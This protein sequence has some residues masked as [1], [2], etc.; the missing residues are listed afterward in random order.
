MTAPY[1]CERVVQFIGDSN[2]TNFNRNRLDVY[3][4]NYPCGASS[5]SLEH[6]AQSIRSGRFAY[7][8]YGEAKNLEVYQQIRPPLIDL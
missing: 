2:I 5:K 8:D 6:Y 1:I 7:F 3:L 4:A